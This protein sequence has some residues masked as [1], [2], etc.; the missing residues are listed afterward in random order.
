MDITFENRLS[1]EEKYIL[2]NTRIT[3]TAINMDWLVTAECLDDLERFPEVRLKF[4]HFNTVKQT[5][6]LNSQFESPHEGGVTALAFS[7]SS[8]TNDLLCASAG[9]D[10]K[11]KIWRLEETII[12]NE[13]A[14]LD[15][16]LNNQSKCQFFV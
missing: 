4:W 14:P 3:H 16:T 12:I 9:K 7:N 1:L 2:Y 5:Y 15:D 11:V 8:I 13:A 6:V 10:R